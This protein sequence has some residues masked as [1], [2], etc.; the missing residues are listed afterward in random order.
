LIQENN[1]KWGGD[2]ETT[3]CILLAQLDV[4]IAKIQGI[5]L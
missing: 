4:T 1:P 2:T 5:A 3:T